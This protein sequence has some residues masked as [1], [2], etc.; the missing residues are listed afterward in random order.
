V[1]TQKIS[2]VLN[3]FCHQYF[4]KKYVFSWRLKVSRLSSRR[5][6]GS[7]FQVDGLTTAKCRPPK[8]DSTARLTS[9]DWQTADVDNQWRSLLACNYPWVIITLQYKIGSR[10]WNLRELAHFLHDLL[11][12]P[13]S[14]ASVWSVI[15]AHYFTPFKRD[16]WNVTSICV[17][18]VFTCRTH[19]RSWSRNKYVSLVYNTVDRV[20]TYLCIMLCPVPPES[21]PSIRGLHGEDLLRR[22]LELDQAKRSSDVRTFDPENLVHQVERGDLLVV[23]QLAKD[24]PQKVGTLS[25]QDSLRYWNVGKITSYCH[26]AILMCF[27]FWSINNVFK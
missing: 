21:L 26:S 2:D 25:V 13:I 3:T 22:L 6:S 19:H 5:L 24:H 8:F 15:S 9:V 4:A 16:D 7:E 14:H 11:L 17:Q 18:H 1:H 10:L 20:E 27:A 12:S 23:K